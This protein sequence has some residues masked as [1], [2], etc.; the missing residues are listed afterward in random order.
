MQVVALAFET[1][2]RR[3]SAVRR[4]NYSETIE[5]LGRFCFFILWVVFAFVGSLFSYGHWLLACRFS[6]DSDGPDEAQQFASYSGNDL[7]LVLACS[8]QPSVALGES[9]LRLPGNLLD[10]FWE[11]FLSL[12]Q[13]GPDGRPVPI[14][15][16]RL[17]HDTSQ[18]CVA[19]LGDAPLSLSLATGVFAGNC[20]AVTHQLPRR[21]EARDL[22][23]LS[24]NRHRRNL[25]DAAQ[26]L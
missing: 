16:C 18:M 3:T 1:L 11:P 13:P 8:R 5:W 14:T 6:L 19:C 22:A 2:P 9:D 17:D 21:I 25:R 15:P 7:A 4:R 24:H 12:A 26:S 23:Q 10:W 20:A